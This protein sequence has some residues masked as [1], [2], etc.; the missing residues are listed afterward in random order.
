MRN[1]NLHRSAS[2]TNNSNHNFRFLQPAL[3]VLKTN[4]SDSILAGT[5][6]GAED[7]RRTRLARTEFNAV[8]SVSDSQRT[9]CRRISRPPGLT[10]STTNGTVLVQRAEG[11]SFDVVRVQLAQ[12][13]WQ[14][15]VVEDDHPG[16]GVVSNLG[17]NPGGDRGAAALRERL[18]D[19]HINL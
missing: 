18:D 14:G 4:S 6:T 1:C 8:M 17:V 9:S 13:D 12:R 2:P 3:K 15:A 10:I 19:G 7:E 5:Q 16:V 11:N